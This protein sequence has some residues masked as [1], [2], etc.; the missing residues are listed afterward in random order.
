[1]LTFLISSCNPLQNDHTTDVNLPDKDIRYTRPSLRKIYESI[2]F[3]ESLLRSTRLDIG[4]A[5][6]AAIAVAI[7]I[8]TVMLSSLEDQGRVLYFTAIG[9]IQIQL[10]NLQDIDIA[11]AIVDHETSI[12]TANSTDI[13]S[14]SLIFGYIIIID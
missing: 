7:A 3:I 4:V 9:I 14:V 8:A 1:M 6:A 11:F 10:I 5:I 13:A 12:D 2:K